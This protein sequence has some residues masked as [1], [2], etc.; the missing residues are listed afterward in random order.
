VA[1][2]SAHSK[3]HDKSHVHAAHG[4]PHHHEHNEH[5]AFL[6][7]IRE[8]KEAEKAAGEKV[9]QAKKE[10]ATIEAMGRE[11]AVEITVKANEKAVQAKN[12]MLAEGRQKTDREVSSI[13]G[14]SK[15]HAEKI[16]SKRL[17]DREVDALSKSVL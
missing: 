15:K 5:D 14:E 7:S 17:V 6:A 11:K 10:A 13:L 9:E 3:P 8:L 12:E 4:H 16:R 2:E 1:N